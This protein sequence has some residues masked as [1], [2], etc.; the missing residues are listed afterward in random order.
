M[1]TTG[2]TTNV[3]RQQIYSEGLQESF[4][5]NVLGLILLNDMTSEFPDGDTFNVDQIGQATLSDYAENTEVDYS[6]IDTSRITLALTDYVQDGFYITDKVNQDVWKSNLLF[7]KRI[8]ESMFAFGK[9][10][11]GDLYNAANAS[12]TAANPNTINAQPHR[13]ALVNGYTAQAFVDRLADIKLSF[14]KANV[15][16]RKVS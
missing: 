16:Y 14:D 9:R 4:K 15:L 5:D 10:L 6:A 11:E 7:S 12:Q 8:K 3:T 2:N 1:I 13:S